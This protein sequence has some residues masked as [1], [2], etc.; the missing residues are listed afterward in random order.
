MPNRIL[1]ESI[2]ISESIDS[3]T[4]FEETAFYRLI[5]NCD[6]FGR[7]DGRLPVIRSRLFPLKSV[8]DKQIDTAIAKMA[9]AGM[10][11]TYI[12]DGK[13]YLQLVNWEQYQQIRAKKSKFPP[14]DSNCNQ[15][16]SDDI[17][18]YRNPIQSN[19]IRIQSESN[20][21]LNVREI[22]DFFE[23]VWK[24]Y[25]KKEGKGSISV[26]QKKKLYEIGLDEM[27]RA[28]ERYNKKLSA[29][30]TEFRFIKQGSTFFNSGYVDYI[31]AN[32]QEPKHNKKNANSS[33]D[34]DEIE[35]MIRNG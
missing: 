34:M 1:R 22:N 4:S 3:L 25:P 14:P 9:T 29:E 35:Q 11:C 21:N 24:A 33:L 31:D 2:C 10:V 13:P 15:M 26:T 5:V 23:S 28:V 6:D 27:M 19:P 20:P 7:F 18:C 16:I 32:Y 8:T 30:N 17:K 12:V